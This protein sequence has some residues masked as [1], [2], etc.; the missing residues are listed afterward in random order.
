M[1]S[2][3]DND[4]ASDRGVTSLSLLT[5]TLMFSVLIFQ[6]LDYMLGLSSLC[7]YLDPAPILPDYAALN[8]RQGASPRLLFFL[9]TNSS[10]ESTPPH[11]STHLSKAAYCD[12]DAP[13][14]LAVYLRTPRVKK[15]RLHASPEPPPLA[16][17]RKPPILSPTHRLHLKLAPAPTFDRRLEDTR[18]VSSEKRSP[19]QRRHSARA[20]RADDSPLKL[21]KRQTPRRRRIVSTHLTVTP[22]T[23]FNPTPPTRTT[24]ASWA[25]RPSKIDLPP[26]RFP[27]TLKRPLS[28]RALAYTSPPPPFHSRPK[29]SHERQLLDPQD[30]RAP[31]RVSNQPHAKEGGTALRWDECRRSIQTHQE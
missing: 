19:P 23:L 13:A 21:P 22:R 25:R 16:P 6:R 11:H 27:C 14:A 3:K 15:L 1:P 7:L 2:I 31:P 28:R 4:D 5:T 26:P 18:H 10:L 17:A 24:P 12:T 29:S 9:L 20:P 8:D 30:L